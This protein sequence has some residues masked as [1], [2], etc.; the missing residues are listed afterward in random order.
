[1]LLIHF[2]CFTPLHN[3]VTS[4]RGRNAYQKIFWYEVY[5]SEYSP[6]VPAI[7]LYS[8][9]GTLWEQD[10]YPKKRSAPFSQ[11]SKNFNQWERQ[12]HGHFD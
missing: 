5:F 7:I 9:L 12:N 1:M 10:I 8:N 6:V 11:V 4:E 2:I 3:S